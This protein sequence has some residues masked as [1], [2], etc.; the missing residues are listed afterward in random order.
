MNVLHRLH[1]LKSYIQNNG[2]KEVILRRVVDRLVHDYWKGKIYLHP[3]NFYHP[4]NSIQ[5][6]RPIFLLGTQGGGGTIVSRLLRQHPDVVYITG[7][8]MFWGGEDELHNIQRFKKLPDEWVLRSPGYNNLLGTEEYHPSF[9]Y[10]RSWLYATNALLPWYRLT[11]SHWSEYVENSIVN[12]LKRCIRAYAKDPH[13][14]RFHDMSQS[15][16]L[17]VPLLKKIFPDAKFILLIRNPFAM[18]WREVT[19]K[20]NKYRHFAKIPDQKQALQ[21]AVEHWYNTY[22]IALN[23]LD[24][25]TDNYILRYEDFVLEPEKYVYTLLDFCDLDKERYEL[26]A[27]NMN[28]PL[29]TKSRNKWWPVSKHA[30]FGYLQDIPKWAIDTIQYHCSDIVDDFDYKY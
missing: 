24:D 9:G 28:I 30:N 3:R 20:N 19:K 1:N 15:F 10:E 6:E 16:A 29:G 22:S 21:W 5:I 4:L 13:L 8:N 14:A 23:D 25:N 27:Y 7:N 17:K 2:L 26:P 12:V 11:E 18:C